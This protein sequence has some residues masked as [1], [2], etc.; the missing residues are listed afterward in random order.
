MKKV[1]LIFKLIKIALFLAVIWFAF[2][3]LTVQKQW[4]ASQN[5]AVKLMNDGK[6]EE[7]LGQLR[8]IVARMNKN[9]LPGL[10]EKNIEHAEGLLA[11]CLVAL[12]DE[13]YGS[14]LETNL[15]RYREAYELDPESID[16]PM[17]KKLLEQRARD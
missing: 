3:Y 2:Q 16:N 8:D 12:A 7:A 5:W 9:N 14:S 1:R 4:V 15:K 6:Y 13:D 17:I 10:K 11:R